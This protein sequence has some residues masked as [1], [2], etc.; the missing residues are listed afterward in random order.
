[1]IA[2]A[3]GKVR[4]LLCKFTIIHTCLWSVFLYEDNPSVRG[5]PAKLPVAMLGVRD[6]DVG[7]QVICRF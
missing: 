5:R 7:G 1:M 6:L 4:N 3:A 2:D